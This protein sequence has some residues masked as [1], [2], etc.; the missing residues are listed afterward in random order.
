MFTAKNERGRYTQ[1]ETTHNQ[2]TNW[3]NGS[4]N[5]NKSEK[6]KKIKPLESTSMRDDDGGIHISL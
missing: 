5:N 2:R 1:T 6:R 3:G 4:L